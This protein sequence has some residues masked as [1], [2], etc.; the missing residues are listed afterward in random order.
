M[1]VAMLFSSSPGASTG[2]V[3]S[4]VKPTAMSRDRASS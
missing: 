3:P 4:S 1:A 2:Y